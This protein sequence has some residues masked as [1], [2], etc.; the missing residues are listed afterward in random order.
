MCN[1]GAGEGCSAPFDPPEARAA[2]EFTG[3]ALAPRPS[4]RRVLM[5]ERRTVTASVRVSPAELA[6]WRTKAVAAGVSLSAL[7]RQTMARTWNRPGGRAG[8]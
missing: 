8:A 5:A 3:G 4:C 1:I 7:L 6:D 2:A